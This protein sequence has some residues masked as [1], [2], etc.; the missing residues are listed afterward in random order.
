MYVCMYRCMYVYIYI[1]MYIC[2][3]VI[4]IYI[5]VCVY[6]YIYIYID[7]Y[8]YTYMYVCIYIYIYICIMHDPG[9]TSAPGSSAPSRPGPAPTPYSQSTNWEWVFITGGCSRRGLQWMGVVLY[10]QLVYNIIR[11]TTPC[12]LCTPLWWILNWEWSFRVLKWY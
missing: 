10:N 8:M 5:Y 1:Y 11:I 9:C 4:Y 12:F 6:T 7:R 2:I 3:Y